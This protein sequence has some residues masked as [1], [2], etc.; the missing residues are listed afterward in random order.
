MAV[1]RHRFGE[2]ALFGLAERPASS[3]KSEPTSDSDTV[4]DLLPG[5][6]PILTR[7][8]SSASK[9]FSSHEVELHDSFVSSSL[10]R[11]QPKLYKPRRADFETIRVLV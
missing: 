1:P 2:S 9:F 10:N 6:I 4:G 11:A 7:Q 5:S 8:Q 3:A